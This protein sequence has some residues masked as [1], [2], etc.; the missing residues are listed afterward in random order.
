M[1]YKRVFW[2]LVFIGLGVLL[3]AEQVTGADYG[4][5]LWPVLACLVGLAIIADKVTSGFH[6]ALGLYIGGYG[7]AEILYDAGQI[8]FTGSD[9]LAKGWPVLLIGLGL[10]T[11]IDRK[12]W[13]RVRWDRI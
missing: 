11:L 9:V 3:L 4:L 1:A 6:W 10:D 12:S 7:L 2:G 8:T 13:I 5:S